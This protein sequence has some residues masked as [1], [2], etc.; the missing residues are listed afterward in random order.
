M[1]V[2]FSHWSL[3]DDQRLITNHQRLFSLTQILFTILQLCRLQNGYGFDK[4]F[5]LV[6]GATKDR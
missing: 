2:I 1:S 6:I 3:A 5:L 4:K